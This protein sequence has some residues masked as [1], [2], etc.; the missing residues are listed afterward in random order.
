MAFVEHSPTGYFTCLHRLA[1]P[2][3]AVGH[4]GGHL[5]VALGARFE[6]VD[7]AHDWAQNPLAKPTQFTLPTDKEKA[8]SL[9]LTDSEMAELRKSEYPCHDIRLAKLVDGELYVG[10]ILRTEPNLSVD[11]LTGVGTDSAPINGFFWPIGGRILRPR[12]NSCLEGRWTDEDSAIFKAIAE[13]KIDPKKIQQIFYLGTGRT[14]FPEEMW[15]YGLNKNNSVRSA[16]IKMALPQMT[17][18]RNYVF[19]IDPDTSLQESATIGPMN[20]MNKAEYAS[21]RHEFCEYE[22]TFY[23]CLFRTAAESRGG[24]VWP[25]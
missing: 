1:P 15:Y 11:P 25:K 19:L 9:W 4:S 14:H 13:V 3:A 17:L 10:F 12:P 20:W 8:E 16:H 7:L 2:N 18:N 22:Q 6:I 21:R 5:V 24:H 23:D